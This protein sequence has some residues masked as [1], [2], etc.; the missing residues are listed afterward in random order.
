LA[1]HWRNGS[2]LLALQSCL[3]SQ[4][5]CQNIHNLKKT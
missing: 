1:Q 5:D 4:I 3:L 2:P